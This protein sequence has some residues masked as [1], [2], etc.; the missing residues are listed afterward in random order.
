MV[1]LKLKHPGPRTDHI[2]E[3]LGTRHGLVASRVEDSRHDLRTIVVEREAVTATMATAALLDG[4]DRDW[5]AFLTIVDAR[6]LP[7]PR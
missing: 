2:L 1:T 3:Q 7:E 6:E 4:V 5:R